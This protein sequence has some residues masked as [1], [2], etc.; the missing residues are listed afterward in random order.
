QKSVASSLNAVENPIWTSLGFRI[1]LKSI[2][3]GKYADLPTEMFNFSLR[4]L[5]L[6]VHNFHASNRKK[7]DTFG[8]NPASRNRF[9]FSPRDLGIPAQYGTWPSLVLS[10]IPESVSRIHLRKDCGLS[11]AARC[12]PIS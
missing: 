11:I 7:D 9:S 2:T 12:R 3:I 10:D 6:S 1:P 4:M 5:H 8:L